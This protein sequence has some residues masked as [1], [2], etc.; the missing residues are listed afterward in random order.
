M[1]PIPIAAL[2][3]GIRLTPAPRRAIVD[4]LVL[5][6]GRHR[7]PCGNAVAALLDAEGCVTQALLDLHQRAAALLA[8]DRGPNRC[9]RCLEA[10]PMATGDRCRACA[11]ER[12]LQRVGMDDDRAAPITDAPEP[13]PAPAAE[14]PSGA[15]LD[16]IDLEDVIAMCSRKRAY[17]SQIDADRVARNCERKRRV[18]LRTYSCPACGSWHIAKQSERRA[19]QEA[20]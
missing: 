2:A 12:Q 13:P 3:V 14:P 15:L 5:A 16:R 20:A 17:P 6:T 7:G 4:L 8:G 10:R 1:T 9:P 11:T 19:A 18:T